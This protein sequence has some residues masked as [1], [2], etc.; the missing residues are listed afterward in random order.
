MAVA[1]GVKWKLPC[2]MFH[3]IYYEQ[4]TL[5]STAAGRHRGARVGVCVGIDIGSALP[6]PCHVNANKA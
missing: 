6:L 3:E 4:G 1:R 5:D 2:V